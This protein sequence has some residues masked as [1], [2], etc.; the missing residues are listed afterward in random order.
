VVM[1]RL[2]GINAKFNINL[3]LGSKTARNADR[4]TEDMSN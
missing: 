1:S 3:S 4:R 2:D